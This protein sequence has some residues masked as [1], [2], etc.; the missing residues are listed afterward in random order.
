[1][2]GLDLEVCL[3]SLAVLVREGWQLQ[4]I[5]LLDPPR[6]PL[7]LPVEAIDGQS[8]LIPISQ[9]RMQWEAWL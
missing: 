3:E 4:Q 5:T 2:C 8:M 9:L 6:A 7:H 1:M